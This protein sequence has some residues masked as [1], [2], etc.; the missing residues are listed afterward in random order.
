MSIR[1]ILFEEE[2]C[3]I[4][5]FSCSIREPDV[6]VEQTELSVMKIALEMVYFKISTIVNTM[7]RLSYGVSSRYQVDLFNPSVYLPVE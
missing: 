1:D 7:G 3:A 6:V 4:F 2:I 5:V